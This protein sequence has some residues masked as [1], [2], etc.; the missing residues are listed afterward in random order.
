MF[1]G[2]KEEENQ[3]KRRRRN[4][5]KPQ[6]PSIYDNTSET[7]RPRP[8]VERERFFF[9]SSERKN[10]ALSAEVPKEQ[11]YQL[12]LGGI[13]NKPRKPPFRQCLFAFLRS[14]GRPTMTCLRLKWLS[15]LQNILMIKRRT[16]AFYQLG[17]PK[18]RPIR[19]QFLQNL[20]NLSCR[21]KP[22]EPTSALYN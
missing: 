9:R 2:L 1:E 14:V 4:Q 19:V 11:C 15:F 20:R 3:N 17:M 10:L 6:A 12:V 13:G 16:L 18:T 21:T 22:S 8:S 5:R 7:K